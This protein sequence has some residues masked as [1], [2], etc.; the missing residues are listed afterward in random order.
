MVHLRR[1]PFKAAKSTLLADASRLPQP[2]EFPSTFTTLPAG[3]NGYKSTEKSRVCRSLATP[4]R[5]ERCP[6]VFL[7]P[8]KRVRQSEM[9]AT[10]PRNKASRQPLWLAASFF[11]GEWNT[12]D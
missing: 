3:V 1:Q 12:R 9:P 10:Q 6:L 4:T 2:P 7:A 5:R 11:I 8:R